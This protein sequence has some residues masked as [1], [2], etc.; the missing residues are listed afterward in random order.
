[1]SRKHRIGLYAALVLLLAALFAG[2][3]FR[4]P[5]PRSVRLKLNE[6]SDFRGPRTASPLPLREVLSLISEKYETTIMIDDLAFR[7][8]GI[9]DVGQTEVVLRGMSGVRLVTALRLVLSQVNASFQINN[10]DFIVVPGGQVDLW[11]P[12]DV[13][14][15]SESLVAWSKRRLRFEMEL[16]AKLTTPLPL[17]RLAPGTPLHEVLE[18]LS[19]GYDVNIVADRGAFARR[20]TA[21]VDQLSVQLD[22][23]PAVAL[24]PVL[25]ALLDRLDATIEVYQDVILVVPKRP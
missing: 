8:Q 11:A 10:G 16:H 14:L 23:Q 9:T 22:P 2:F 3:Y 12:V 20:G 25:R 4:E 6:P 24:I 15:P 19:D 21:D 17:E 1:M 5:I 13:D 7:L 18:R